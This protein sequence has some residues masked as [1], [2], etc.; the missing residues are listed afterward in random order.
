MSLPTRL[1]R[2]QLAPLPKSADVEIGSI[3]NVLDP[4]GTIPATHAM[5]PAMRAALQAR[6]NELTALMQG[7]QED[8]IIDDLLAMFMNLRR[9]KG[10]ENDATLRVRNYCGILADVPPF[11]VKKAIGNYLFGNAG[12]GAFA[13]TAPELRKEALRY[14]EP[15]RIEKARITKALDAKPRESQSAERR[16]RA[17]AHAQETI[18]QLQAASLVDGAK[19]K[20]PSTEGV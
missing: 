6:I 13:P 9:P 1:S 19:Y 10:D 4:D 2:L 3:L 20:I 15:F 14:V 18:R 7:S 16:D 17:L 11:A 8:E 12:D 5:K